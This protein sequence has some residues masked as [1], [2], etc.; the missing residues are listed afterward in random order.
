MYYVLCIMWQGCEEIIGGWENESILIKSIKSFVSNIW[1]PTEESKGGRN[2][3]WNISSSD[4]FSAY[5][6]TT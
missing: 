3:Y 5:Q 4:N 6:F 2:I 1:I